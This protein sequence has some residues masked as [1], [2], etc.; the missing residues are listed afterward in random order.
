MGGTIHG[1]RLIPIKLSLC[2][3]CCCGTQR[4]HPGIDHA[5]IRDRLAGAAASTGGRSRSVGCL[6]VCERSNVVVVKTP[7][8]GSLWVGEV[9]EEPL[10]A[11]LEAWIRQGAPLPVPSEVAGH[12]FDRKE[13]ADEAPAEPVVEYVSMRSG[14][15]Q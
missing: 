13:L 12:L 14:V 10:V 7:H 11:E 9:L 2:D 1:M 3:D 5:R 15:G 8:A 4:K 6:G